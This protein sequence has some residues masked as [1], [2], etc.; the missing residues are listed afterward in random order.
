MR[1]QES[2]YCNFIYTEKEEFNILK[3]ISTLIINF[4]LKECYKVHGSINMQMQPFLVN[5]LLKI[6][7]FSMINVKL[8]QAFFLKLCKHKHVIMDSI[9]R[10]QTF[11][12]YFLAALFQIC[13][14]YSPYLFQSLLSAK[15]SFSVILG[16]RCNFKKVRSGSPAT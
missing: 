7:G 5:A 8:Q 11:Y 3:F 4:L 15:Y 13:H 12:I 9:Q 6:P 16:F 1:F 10:N 2:Y 14:Q